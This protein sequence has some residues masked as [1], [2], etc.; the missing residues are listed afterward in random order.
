MAD[1]E[2]QKGGI[3]TK[4]IV[5]TEDPLTGL[6]VQTIAYRKPN[7]DAGSWTAV[8]EGAESISYTTTSNDDLDEVGDWCLQANVTVTSWSGPGTKTTLT[9]LSNC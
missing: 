5:E 3:G 4:I 2:V 1:Q 8:Q 9:V 6:S 7:G